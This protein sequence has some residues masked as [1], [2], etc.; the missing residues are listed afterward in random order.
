MSFVQHANA[1]A[2]SAADPTVRR[3]KFDSSRE[4]TGNFRFE[5][6]CTYHGEKKPRQILDRSYRRVNTRPEAVR[7]ACLPIWELDRASHWRISCAM[8]MTIGRV[9][10]LLM[11]AVAAATT[12]LALAY[13]AHFDFG[14][15]RQQIRTPAIVGAGVITVLVAIEFFGKKL[16]KRK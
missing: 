5:S 15:S 10:S 7:Q 12:A 9:L 13:I 3:S 11:C 1:L 16:R 2:A 6:G 8:E 14:L 4:D